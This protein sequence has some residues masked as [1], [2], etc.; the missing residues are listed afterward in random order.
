M[1]D[2]AHGLT[3]PHTGLTPTNHIKFEQVLVCLPSS[4]KNDFDLH[5]ISH[6]IGHALGFEHLH[7]IDSVKKRL[8]MT[9][10]GLGCSVMPYSE[11]LT[12]TINSCNTAQYC[13]Y[14]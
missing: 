3:A 1:A 9:P 4:V 8:K 13:L 12:S 7:D 10:Q 2:N 6:E 11:K 14:L 5:T